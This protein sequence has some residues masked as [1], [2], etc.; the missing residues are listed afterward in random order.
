MK[1]FN[2]FAFLSLALVALLVP[3]T[4]FAQVSRTTGALQGT[5]TD[6]QGNA[7]PGVTVT[8]TSPNLQGS[9]V[10]VTDAKGE[11]VLPA[12]PPGQYHVDYSLT[13]IKSATRDVTVNLNQATRL[14]VPM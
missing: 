7:L 11:Y 9:R 1:K 5:V 6:G 10:V 12:L 13:G 3:F 4:A 14:D 8:V 2:R